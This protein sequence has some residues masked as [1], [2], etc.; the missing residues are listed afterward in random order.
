MAQP[1]QHQ[2]IAAFDRDGRPVPPRAWPDVLQ[3]LHVTLAPV[4]D[5][6]CGMCAAGACHDDACR[7]RFPRADDLDPGAAHEP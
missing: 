2:V 6:Q 4:L 1:L 7:H 3:R 5:P